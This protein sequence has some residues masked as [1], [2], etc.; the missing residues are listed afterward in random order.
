MD[1]ENEV[2]YA[3]ACGHSPCSPI[4]I[5]KE[6]MPLGGQ[7]DRVAIGRYGFMKTAV[8]ADASKLSIEARDNV[9]GLNESARIPVDTFRGMRLTVQTFSIRV[10]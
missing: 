5:G 3:G 7:A 4:A 2:T 9:R 6:P 8:F 1:R 10:R